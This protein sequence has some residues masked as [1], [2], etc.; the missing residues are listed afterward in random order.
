MKVGLSS[1]SLERAIAS[2]EMSVTDAVQ[3]IADHGGSHMEVVPAGYDLSDNPEL[4]DA[5]RLKAEDAGIELSNYAVGANF[6]ADNEEAYER[7]VGRVMREV[8]IAARLGV[9]R[10]RHDAGWS[11]EHSVRCFN[12]HLGRMADA[13]RRIADYA[14]P[15]GITTSIEN[16]GYLVQGSD[17]V[18]TLVQAV[19]RPNFKLTMDIGNFMCADEDSVAASRRCLPYASMVHVKDFYLRHPA[20]NPGEGWFPTT[21]GNFLRGAIVGHGDVDMP[22][23]MAAIR[24]SGFDGYLSIEFEGLEDCR[25]AS[26]MGLDYLSRLAKE[27]GM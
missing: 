25:Q 14:A 6:I 20:R 5:I 16:H 13:C 4:I 18:L 15:Y 9:K 26:R 8:D 10:M 19:D 23:V 24:D 2:G 7:E 12:R 11:D 1:Y 22:G 3:W 27:L 21:R 17:R